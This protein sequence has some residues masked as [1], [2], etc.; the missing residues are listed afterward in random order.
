MGRWSPVHMEFAGEQYRLGWHERCGDRVVVAQFPST[1]RRAESTLM[2]FAFLCCRGRTGY[3]T[4]SA[5]CLKF[6]PHQNPITLYK[7]CSEALFHSKTHNKK[8]PLQM[9]QCHQTQGT[10]TG[11]VFRYSEDLDS[12]ATSRLL[13]G[14]PRL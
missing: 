6:L 4:E 3:D 1:V 9:T 8:Y 7:S 12:V 11:C 10:H 2:V 5:S 14:S 13:Q